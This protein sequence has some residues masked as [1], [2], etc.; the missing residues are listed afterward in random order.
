MIKTTKSI[1]YCPSCLFSSQEVLLQWQEGVLHGLTERHLRTSGLPGLGQRH[2][3]P[4][5]VH[6]AP[7]VPRHQAARQP[8]PHHS[9]LPRLRPVVLHDRP[10]HPLPD[11]PHRRLWYVP[12][13]LQSCLYTHHHIPRV[14][15]VFLTCSL[16][17]ILYIRA[18][19]EFLYT[20]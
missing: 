8:L 13:Y 6:M 14:R 11:L 17:K 20:F 18:G 7:L 9:R 12:F 10:Q 1:I 19:C 5:H 4:A 15:L 16:R 3:Q 2:S